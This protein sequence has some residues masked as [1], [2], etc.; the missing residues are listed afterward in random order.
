M[1]RAG[2]DWDEMAVALFSACNPF[3]QEPLPDFTEFSDFS[4][5][6]REFCFFYGNAR[7]FN[8]FA[9]QWGRGKGRSLVPKPLTGI[10]PL[11]VS[12][13][14]FSPISHTRPGYC[15]TSVFP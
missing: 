7:Q 1:R 13:S 15:L 3:P 9:H 6:A 8:S 14:A 11:G 12:Y 2:E 5:R 10:S 4:K